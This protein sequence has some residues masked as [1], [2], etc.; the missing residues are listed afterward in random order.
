V[1]DWFTKWGFVVLNILLFAC[2]II[3][4]RSLEIGRVSAPLPPQACRD[5]VIS[6]YSL[7]SLSAGASCLPG[8]RLTVDRA[9]GLVICECPD[10]LEAPT[11]QSATVSPWEVQP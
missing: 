3:F 6:T 5:S 1:T 9:A 4:G 10:V 11:I 8:A 2:G 7:D